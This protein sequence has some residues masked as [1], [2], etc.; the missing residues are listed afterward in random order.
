MTTSQAPVVEEVGTGPFPRSG[1]RIDSG[2]PSLP[3]GALDDGELRRVHVI[4]ADPANDAE[5]ARARIP[6]PSVYLVR[7][8]GHVGLSGAHLDAA[9][10]KRYLSENLRLAKEIEFGGER[11]HR[12]VTRANHSGEEHQ[13]VV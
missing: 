1:R 12:Q 11:S 4:P 10:V 6:Q 13:R 5:L 3:Q 8:D 9:A 2:Q 7:P